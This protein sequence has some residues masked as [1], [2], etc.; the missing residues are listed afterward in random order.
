M[1]LT[2]A[3]LGR[4]SMTVRP[5]PLWELV[6][7]LHV[8]QARIVPAPYAGWRQ[9]VLR[10]LARDG[11]L[12]ER[13]R[14]LTTLVPA[15]GDF[16]D[17]LTPDGSGGFT[18]LLEAVLAT[19]RDRL[20][21]ELA[22]LPTPWVRE[23]ADGNACALRELGAALTHYHGACV[24]PYWEQVDERV[25]AE[26]ELRVRILLSGGSEQL[27]RSLPGPI[28]WDGD[29][30]VADYPVRQDV[31]VDGR[32]LTLVPAFFC[33][34]KPVS[35]VDPEL[36]PVLVYPVGHP[37]DELHARSSGGLTALLGPTRARM[38]H[39]LRTPCSTTEIARHVGISVGSASRQATVL[40]EA[41][42]ITS[43]RHEKAVVHAL[44][45]LGHTI[46]GRTC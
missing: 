6:L 35:F 5:H 32:G 31:R 8:L 22:G 46:T 1:R 34:H 14:R 9:W 25:T 43:V 28:R 38:L 11:T 4:I 10:V 7:S 13:V 2:A 27:L 39:V 42:L 24:A 18:D 29:T 40:R 21:R 41:G 3:D 26:R 45:N 15:T 16:P 37:D 30:L 23:L 20:A 12:R 17:F 33:W 44:T 36:P 19:P